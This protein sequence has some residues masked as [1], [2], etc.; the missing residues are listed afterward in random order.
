MLRLAIVLEKVIT[1]LLGWAPIPWRRAVIGRPD[2][3][4]RIAT[5]AYDFL[6]RVPSGESQVYELWLLVL[7]MRVVRK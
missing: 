2:N 6:N 1:R 7:G 3:P 4:S 5:L